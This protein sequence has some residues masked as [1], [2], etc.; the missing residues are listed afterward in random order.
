MFRTSDTKLLFSEIFQENSLTFCL[1]FRKNFWLKGKR[2]VFPFLKAIT[3]S[4]K[5]INVLF[6]IKDELTAI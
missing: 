5:D 2:A 3:Y 4:E 6:L 1:P